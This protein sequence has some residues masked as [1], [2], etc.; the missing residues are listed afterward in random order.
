MERGRIR[1]IAR[2]LT[3]MLLFGFLCLASFAAQPDDP[4][5]PGNAVD[6]PKPA[7]KA[8]VDDPFAPS[9]A[10]DAAPKLSWQIDY[11][12][13]WQQA[14]AENKLIFIDFT[15]VTCV[16]CRDNEERV[17]PK[18]DVR[19]ELEKF[20]RLQ[21]F[22]DQVPKQALSAKQARNEADRNRDWQEKTFGD[23]ST[24]FYVVFKPAKD[25]A[26]TADGKLNGTTVAI[27][28]KGKLFDDQ[29]PKFVAV[30]Q[31]ALA[32]GAGPS[33][34]SK[35]EVKEVGKPQK[36]AERIDLKVSVKPQQVRR[37]ETFQVSI[38]ATPKAGFYTYPVARRTAT[39]DAG[40]MNRIAFDPVPGLTPLYPNGESPE[41]T[42]YDT[43]LK[44]WGV[45]LRH[46]NAVTWTQD[47]LV[48]P[49]AKPGQH[50]LRLS[51][52]IQVCQKDCVFGTHVFE[53]PVEVT[54]APPAELTAA[55]KQRLEAKP[56]AKVVPVPTN[57]LGKSDAATK[58]GAT[59]PTVPV[60]Q[61]A[62]APA[63]L[64]SILLAAMSSALLML[65]TPCVFPMIPITVSFFAKQSE[66]EHNRPFM[67]AGVY[68]LTIIIVLAAAV[69][70]LGKLIID[71]ANNRW[72]NFGLGLVMIYFSL[73]LFGMYDIELPGFLARFTSAREGQG[74]IVGALFMALTFT[75]TSFS[76]T[77]PFLGPLLASASFLQVDFT[78]LLLASLVYAATFAA[79]FFILA[80][81]PGMVK[82]L[83][84]SGGWM[85]TVKVVMG[86]V[87]VALA[88][89]FFG[90]ADAAFFP[91]DPL[92][93]NYDTVLCGWIALSVAVSLYLLGFFRL[94]HDEP[95]EH[96]GVVRMLAATIFFGLALYFVPALSRETPLGV[97]GKNM[98]AFLPRDS[99]EKKPGGTGAFAELH[100]NLD[101]QKAWEQAV[102]EDKLIFIDNTGVYC[103]NC[104]YN[105]DHVFTLPDVRRELEK[106]VRVQLYNDQV[107]DRS[108]S[109]AE[110]E[111]AGI[112]NRD[113]QEKTFGDIT[114]PY[115]VVFKP[116]KESAF[117]KDGRLNGTVVG[118]PVGGQI[119]D[120]Q[121][122]QFL[123]ML[124][125]GTNGQAAQV[126]KAAAGQ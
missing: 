83:P 35:G 62:T 91:G 89:K 116:S 81:F 68:S 124:R 26:I 103:I 59:S 31:E 22:T 65:L 79:P 51:L 63:G 6:A 97:I 53:V 110:A 13:A 117:T 20:V 98:R 90:N 86:F 78:T 36:T 8:D 75:I 101:Y 114:T 38:L 123:A 16:N 32:K 104:R 39:Q 77:G 41:P 37:G 42:F 5:A 72:M 113:L 34:A 126:A 125:V 43:H 1:M 60:P 96:I 23:V 73:S 119:F 105:E 93:F 88:L 106:F 21:L 111:R 120:W 49:D 74:G 99:R 47:F 9:N 109:S 30:L 107:P 17:F 14:I 10:V 19:Q 55:L 80:L 67:L 64:V 69:M 82:K 7:K 18:A 50:L 71:L 92:F 118:T 45:I 48:Q 94:P 66:K 112:R 100:W 95:I 4:F 28:W 61:T 87:E 121:V 2:K 40:L 33:T 108:L 52:R 25:K 24:P 56:D 57:L 46:T 115:Y 3:A 15:G 12:P 102:K 85:N 44:D 11:E 54:D 122:P 58:T 76:C 84:K 27:A 70:I 29:I